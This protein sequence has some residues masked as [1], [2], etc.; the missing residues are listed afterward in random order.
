MFLE[1]YSFVLSLYF[2]FCQI[3]LPRCIPVILKCSIRRFVKEIERGFVWGLLNALRILR[4]DERT[5]RLYYNEV[6]RR[7]LSRVKF[8]N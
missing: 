6:S 5:F 1:S 2:C 7:Q 8:S 3:M 4:I